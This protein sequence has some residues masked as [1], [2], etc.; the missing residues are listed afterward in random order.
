MLYISPAFLAITIP[1][2]VLV[3]SVVVFNQLSGDN[4]FVVM[5]ASGW[6]FL[7]LMRPVMAFAVIAYILN[8]LV[9]SMLCP[10]ELLIQK[11]VFDIVR[12]RAN[13]DI[14]PNVFNRDFRNLIILPNPAKVDPNWATCLLQ[15]HQR[16]A[17]TGLS[18]PKRESLSP[19][20]ILLKFNCNS[21]T[22]PF[23]TQPN[24][25]AIIRF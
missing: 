4:E 21:A 8:N 10:G 22:E 18:W 23:T 15:T 16:R 17:Q 6:S 3:A 13:L 24:V 12:H 14:K 5:K 11:M 2:S 25:G 19:T 20:R 1:M 7:Y 9:I